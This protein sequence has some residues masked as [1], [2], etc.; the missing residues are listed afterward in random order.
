[1]M[2]YST[3]INAPTPEQMAKG[4]VPI[5]G[6]WWTE[7]E[8]DKKRDTPYAPTIAELWNY[9]QQY[10]IPLSAKIEYY[11]CGSHTMSLE[12]TVGKEDE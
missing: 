1:M 10:G 4:V 7:N 3:E 5:Q 2:I 8:P 9:M 6:L 11:D 12:W